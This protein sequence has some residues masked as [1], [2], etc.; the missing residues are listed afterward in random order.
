MPVRTTAR[1]AAFIPGASPPDVSTP[2]LVTFDCINEMNSKVWSCKIFQAMAR[3][4][5]YLL[6]YFK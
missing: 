1:T 5:E 4:V 3:I 2:I 6:P